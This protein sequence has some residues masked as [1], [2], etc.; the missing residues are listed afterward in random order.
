MDIFV[1]LHGL[2]E[3]TPFAESSTVG[4]RTRQLGTTAS[5]HETHDVRYTGRTL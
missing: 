4:R 5:L 2:N 1:D 3:I